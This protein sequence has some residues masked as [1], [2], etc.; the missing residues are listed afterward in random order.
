[1]QKA[2]S[3]SFGSLGSDGSNLSLS[4]QSSFSFPRSSARF[5]AK[6]LVDQPLA[7]P[8]LI[9]A[10]AATPLIPHR[11]QPLAGWHATKMPFTL[12]MLVRVATNIQE[13]RQ[14]FLKLFPFLHLLYHH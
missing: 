7:I 3:Y 9:S 14:D 10:P 4:L 2:F 13:Q 6:A 1:M 8:S 12:G 11:Q 5:R